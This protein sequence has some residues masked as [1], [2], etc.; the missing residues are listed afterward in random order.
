MPLIKGKSKDSFEK[1][2]KTEMHE[3]K[4]M[5][6]SLAIAYNVKRHAKKM[7][8][9]GMLT[10]D[11]YQSECTEHCTQPCAVHEMAEYDS[12]DYNKK[13]PMK[14]DM[15]AMEEDSRK[16]NQH[17]DEEEGPQGTWMA[18]GGMLT[19][20]GYQDE[21]HEMDMVGRIMSQRQKMFSKGGRVA[22]QDSIEAGFSPNEFDDLHLRDELESSYTGANSGDELSSDGEDERRRDMVSRIMASR[23][24]KDKL[25]RPA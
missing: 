20:D 3:G 4:S 17:G 24:K 15:M 9:G 18:E 25:P 19:D 21:D 8:R 2:M 13:H 10:N 23:R 14:P 16:L 7:A 11:G 22:N 6:Q 1:N 5:P 12:A